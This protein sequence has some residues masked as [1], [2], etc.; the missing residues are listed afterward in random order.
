MH[1]SF[2][3]NQQVAMKKIARLVLSL[4]C[5]Y[6]II[7]NA[8]PTQ[9]SINYSIGLGSPITTSTT[10]PMDKGGLGISQRAEYYPSKPFSDLELSRQPGSESQNLSIIN[11]FM[12]NYGLG[13]NITIGTSLPYIYT[14]GIRTASLSEELETLSISNLGN[15]S[16]VGDSSIYSLWRVF[17]EDQYPFSMAL[18]AGI[19]TPNGKSSERDREGELFA[20]A[21]QAGSGS[22]A[23]FGG[24]IFTKKW[25]KVLI[26]TNL[27][28]TQSTEGAQQTQL[29]SLLNVNVG[30]VFQLYEESSTKLQLDGILEL[31]GEYATQ[32]TIAGIIDPDSG[33]SSLFFL[34]G[35][36]LNIN[37]SVSLYLGGNI[38]IFEHYN[39]MQVKYKWGAIGGV[40]F[41][42]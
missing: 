25:D 3:L 23:P 11:Y 7:L 5:C 2:M 1:I 27:I 41:S 22:W 14:S 17:D 39:G 38:P 20:A 30:T 24:M 13:E 15:I 28:Y 8:A 42:I 34:P 37:P 10:D 12:L 40:D 33:G 26:S 4:T 9:K 6:S 31:N 36:R 19:N 21:D 32:S 18:L 35:F 29:S 16:A